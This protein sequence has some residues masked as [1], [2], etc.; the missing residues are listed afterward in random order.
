MLVGIR[1]H[2]WEYVEVARWAVGA[3]LVCCKSTQA[4]MST[5]VVSNGVL[6]QPQ[7][8]KKG[9]AGMNQGRTVGGGYRVISGQSMAPL[10]Q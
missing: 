3:N 7:A 2:A 10:D 5:S 8:G 4:S 6:N 9:T 1:A